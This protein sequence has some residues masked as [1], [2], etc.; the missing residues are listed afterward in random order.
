MTR[1]TD[2]AEY[3]DAPRGWGGKGEGGSA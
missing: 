2:W 1:R 3:E